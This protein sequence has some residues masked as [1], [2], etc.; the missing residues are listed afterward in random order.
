MDRATSHSRGLYADPLVSQHLNEKSRAVA[1][2]EGCH[3]EIWLHEVR[4][5]RQLYCTTDTNFGSDVKQ[6]LLSSS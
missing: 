4:I 1:S 5:Y 3:G 6:H 2:S